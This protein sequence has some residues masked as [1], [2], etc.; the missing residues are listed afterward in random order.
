M[1]YFIPLAVHIRHLNYLMRKRNCRQ[2]NP[3]NIKNELLFSL[4]KTTNMK[5]KNCL[6]TLATLLSFTIANAQTVDEII[7]K[8]IDAIGGKD[9]IS[10][11]NSVIVESTTE[12][13]GNQA[14]TK[15]S[16]VNGKGYRS[17]S[18]FGGQNMVTVITDKGG[19]MINPFA[20]ASDPTALPDDQY[21]QRADDIYAIDPLYNYAANGA[22][23][24][25]AGQESV[26]SV[27][28]YKI[29]FTN[30][31]GKETVFYVDPSTWYVIQAVTQAEAMGQ[32]VT[33]TT[34]LSDFKKTDFGVVFP[35]KMHMDMGQFALDIT[36]NKV[37]FNKD[38]DPKIF[39]M[40][41]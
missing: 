41:K 20:G 7:A 27:N 21:Q 37:E 13:M 17:E 26:G 35:Y 22:K 11:V 29:K 5:I 6:F 8:H 16:I 9:K 30:K 3:A 24:E 36:T 40:G 15:I 19:W 14:P 2:K 18:D 39:E 10:Q 28:A 34:S 1:H 33:V 31:Y 12:V 38:I 32:Q 25:L 23:A 4:Y